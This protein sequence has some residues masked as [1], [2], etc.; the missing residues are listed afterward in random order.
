[1]VQTRPV[2]EEHRRIT[3]QTLEALFPN[4]LPDSVRVRLWD[5]SMWPDY[6]QEPEAQIVLNHPGALRNM[7][8][9]GNEVGLGE[10]Y[11][12]EDFDVSGDLEKV[13]ECAESLERNVAS[14]GGKLNIGSLLLRLPV[15]SR[16]VPYRG[17][18]TLNGQV[19][20]LS[21]DREAVSYHYD[22]SNEFYALWLD[23][24]M[25]Y[26]CAY[27]ET[28][29][30]SIDVAQENKLDYICRKLRLAPGQR[31]LDI[32]CGWGALVAFAAANYGVRARGVTL[33]KP[34]AEYATELLQSLGLSD[35]AH[36]SLLDYRDI[37]AS[38]RYDAIVSVGMFEH[39]GRET[40]PG[41]FQKVFQL[42]RPGGVFLNHGIASGSA[43]QQLEDRNTSFSQ[44]YVFP[45]GEL[46]PIS[47]TLR[48]AHEAGF[49]IRDL[50]SLREH[51]QLTLRHWVHR[52]ESNRDAVIRHV[53]EP[54]YRV[55]RLFMA[56]GAYGFGVGSLN[57]YQAL[58][59]RP[60]EQGR[61]GLSLTREDWYR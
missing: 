18:A 54:T 27:F 21:R 56:G 61:S 42:L 20:S 34:Q 57:V 25:V 13:F 23:R 26:S 30:D 11:L 33:S 58:F 37:T 5:G 48:T 29:A 19:H 14:I 51:Y 32:G 31:L 50:E 52:L 2:E 38:E 15:R 7:L 45:D 10:A 39:V 17:S 55:W 12:N 43:R 49:E 8:L 53:D 35:R 59:V 16:K 24:Q 3:I 4:G 1:M 9:A 44:N 60:T 22:V 36:V 47:T 46:V 6:A 40:L 41:Y 28:P